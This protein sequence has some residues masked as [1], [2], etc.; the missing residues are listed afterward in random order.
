MK[1]G[2]FQ[3]VSSNNSILFFLP[4]C[5]SQI[6][7]PS[8][9]GRF[10]CCIMQKDEHEEDMAGSF[11][12]AFSK[13][14]AIESRYWHR[15]TENI[16]ENLWFLK[17]HT[18]IILN[19]FRYSW[20]GWACGTQP[21]RTTFFFPSWAFLKKNKQYVNI[22]FTYHFQLQHSHI[23]HVTTESNHNDDLTKSDATC[24]CLSLRNQINQHTKRTP[25]EAT[26]HLVQFGEYVQR[27]WPLHIL[28]KNTTRKPLIKFT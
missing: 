19:P 21:A 3:E 11:S 7:S 4:S 8:I 20:R 13:R 15:H 9:E 25:F 23:M 12:A 2:N 27:P 6:K 1:P 10:K 22:F 28:D 18:P 26:A 24:L 16:Y 14:K 17:I 5:H